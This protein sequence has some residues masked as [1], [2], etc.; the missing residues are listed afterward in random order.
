MSADKK[1]AESAVTGQNKLGERI[2]AALAERGAT[3]SLC[4][5]Y[6]VKQQTLGYIINGTTKNTRF[7]PEIAECIGVPLNELERLR[8][9]DLRAAGKS[10]KGNIPQ[11]ARDAVAQYSETWRPPISGSFLPIRGF[12][13]ASGKDM[14]IFSNNDVNE[15]IPMPSSLENVDGAYGIEIVGASMQPRYFPREVVHVNP[16]KT[17]HPDDF[18]VL[19]VRDHVTGQLCGFVKQFKKETGGK[20]IVRQFNPPKTLRFNRDDV[21]GIH[22]IIG[23]QRR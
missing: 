2:G 10:V 12:A 3:Q 15:Q 6:G 21:E 5:A 23:S 9:E 18:V 8:D 20:V 19:H 4:E 17:H 14:V 1:T 13:A 22:V 11:G 16:H 7:L